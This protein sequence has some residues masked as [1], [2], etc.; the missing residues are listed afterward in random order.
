MK[1]SALLLTNA[2]L[3]TLYMIGLLVYMASG[4]GIAQ[5]NGNLMVSFFDTVMGVLLAAHALLTAI[6]LVLL[7]GAYAGNS[8]GFSV[9]SGILFLL[10]AFQAGH[11]L[12]QIMGV[13]FAALSFFGLFSIRAIRHA[14]EERIQRIEEL[15]TLKREE[16]IARAAVARY[17]ETVGASVAEAPHTAVPITT[18]ESAQQITEEI[19]ITPPKCLKN[20]AY[21]LLFLLLAAAL[22]YFGPRVLTWY[23]SLLSRILVWSKSIA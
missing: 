12:P 18:P 3:A 15:E 16:E 17:A 7:W 20:T 5:W 1:R 6:G 14:N 8:A 9:A 10:S 21:T 13:V 2:L 4:T 19:P 22:F 11:L 23:E